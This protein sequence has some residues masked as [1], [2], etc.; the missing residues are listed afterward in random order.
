MVVDDH[1]IDSLK[2]FFE[3]TKEELK[4]EWISG[5]Y[6]KIFYCPSFKAAAAY[7]EAL[8]ILYH[9]AKSPYD[10]AIELEYEID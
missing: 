8:K 3:V 9:G 5:G 6:E 4:K 7:H 2:V 10:A 1:A